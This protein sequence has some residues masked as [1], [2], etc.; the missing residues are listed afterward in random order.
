MFTSDFVTIVQIV[1]NFKCY[2]QTDAHGHTNN[3]AILQRLILEILPSRTAKHYAPYN[4]KLSVC[5]R[6]LHMLNQL[7]YCCDS[8]GSNLNAVSVHCK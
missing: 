7:N 4:T 5:V 2:K 8:N 3:M 6:R 1:Q